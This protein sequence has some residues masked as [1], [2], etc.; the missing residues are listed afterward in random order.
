MRFAFANESRSR[1][2]STD[3]GALDVGCGV[4][5]GAGG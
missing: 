2:L 3:D 1:E 5:A 4:G